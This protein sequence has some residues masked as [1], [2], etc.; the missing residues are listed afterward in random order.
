MLGLGGASTLRRI[1]CSTISRMS[2]PPLLRGRIS[3]DLE[4][5]CALH[6]EHW[7]IP[8]PEQIRPSEDARAEKDRSLR[9]I[10]E[11][12]A[13]LTDFVLLSIFRAPATR[14]RDGRLAAKDPSAEVTPAG[15]GW[16]AAGIQKLFEEAE[17]KPYKFVPNEFPYALHAGSRHW[18]LWYNTERLLK[19]DDEISRDIFRE[20][21]RL[22]KDR[23]PTSAP[24]AASAHTPAGGTELDLSAVDFAWCVLSSHFP[25]PADDEKLQSVCIGMST[26]R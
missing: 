25:G 5:L 4:D 11:E 20:I 9:R 21:R 23:P 19:S 8:G 14:A 10:T 13:S 18:V 22:F 6:R 2:Q 12:Y 3:S 15:E 24:A 16:T 17:L 7:W 1:H 26:R